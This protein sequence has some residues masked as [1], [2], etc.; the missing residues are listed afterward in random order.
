MG[1]RKNYRRNKTLKIKVISFYANDFY[2][3]TT[4]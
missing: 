3:S 1:M 4:N 2:I